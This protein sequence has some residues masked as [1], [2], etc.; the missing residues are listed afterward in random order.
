MKELKKN[1]ILSTSI[2]VTI[3]LILAKVA[4]FGKQIITASLFGTSI[5]TDMMSLSENF[6]SNVDYLMIQTFVTAF[7]PIYIKLKKKGSFFSNRFAVDTIKKLFIFLLFLS[8]VMM[9][10]AP[11]IAK[12]LAPNYTSERTLKLSSYLMLFAPGMI[13]LSMTALFNAILRANEK[14][15]ISELLGLLQHI[16]SIIIILS[17][18]RFFGINILLIS[19]YGYSVVNVALSIIC[20]KKY[21]NI[22]QSMELYAD[23]ENEN[24]SKRM[25]KMILP[26]LLGYSAVFINQ[27][28]DKILVS[29]LE[30]GTITAMS[31]SSVLVN[32]VVTFIGAFCVILFT[33]ITSNIAIKNNTKAAELT[34]KSSILMTT[35]FLPISIIAFMNARDIVDIVYGHG[36]FGENS[37]QMSTYALQGYSIF[38]VPYIYRE[39]YSK[40]IYGYERSLLPTINS[41]IS[42]VINV[43]LSIIFVQYFGVFGVALATSISVITNAIL[44]MVVAKRLNRE[45]HYLKMI[46]YLISWVV[47]GVASY[48]FNNWMCKIMGDSSSLLRFLVC[49]VSTFGVYMILATPIFIYIKRNK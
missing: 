29:G 38:I 7:V 13:I 4:G 1:K 21:W 37:I 34:I 26:L 10:A 27:Q 40:L 47:L 33:H 25:L 16:I 14:F 36:S 11:I 15:I 20:S 8:I 41:V 28:V 22:H 46:I 12:I 17:F 35:I 6:V 9:G 45:L 48:Y 24:D 42:I 18:E 23:Y 32:F 31:Y 2:V 49:S 3:I 43:V 5:E 30:E 39:L 44:N 19:F